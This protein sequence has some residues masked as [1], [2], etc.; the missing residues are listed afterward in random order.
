MEETLLLL[1][2]HL[3]TTL[4]L[5]QT[6]KISDNLR[7]LHNQEPGRLP[8]AT[9]TA[10]ANRSIDLLHQVGQLLEPGHLV[11]AD[12]FLGESYKSTV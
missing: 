4:K 8:S 9:G 11:L 7:D 3:D 10:L 1:N 2:A 5:L 12:H 6:P